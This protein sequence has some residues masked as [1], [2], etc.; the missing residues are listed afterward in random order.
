MIFIL[1]A[2]DIDSFCRANPTS[3][4]PHPSNCAQY[5]NCSDVN[6]RYG[7]YLEEC[8]YPDLFSS[9]TM[10][11]QKFQTVSCDAKHEPKAPCMFI[12]YFVE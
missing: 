7:R 8:T 4:K 11:C 5:Y 1:L 12:N 3:L 2:A 6:S 10:R 9:V